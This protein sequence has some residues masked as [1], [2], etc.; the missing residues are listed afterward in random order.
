M[1]KTG[2]ELITEIAEC[3]AR[4]ARKKGEGKS[5]YWEEIRRRELREDLEKLPCISF[6]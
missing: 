2:V 3:S 1:P 5:A 4:I 6:S